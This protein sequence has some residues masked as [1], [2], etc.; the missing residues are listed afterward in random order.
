[1]YVSDWVIVS[2]DLTDVI[3]ARDDT[4]RRIYWCESDHS[5][6]PD[7]SYLLDESYL[8]MKV[9]LWRKLSSDESYPVMKVI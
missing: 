4:Y 1:M 9:T 5:D 8:A 2:I 7:E 3:L 6:D